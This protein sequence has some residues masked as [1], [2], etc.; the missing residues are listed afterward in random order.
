MYPRIEC[1]HRLTTN[2]AITPPL[3]LIFLLY[4]SVLRIIRPNASTHAVSEQEN[5]SGFSSWYLAAKL[6]IILKKTHRQGERAT[7]GEVYTG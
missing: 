5:T 4:I 7:I 1:S 2:T 6:S 3:T